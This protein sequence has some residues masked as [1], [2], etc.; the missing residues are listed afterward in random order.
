IMIYWAILAVS[1][2]LTYFRKYQEREFRLAQAQLQVLRMQLHPHFLFNTLNA[3]SE[4]VYQAPERADRTITQLSDLLRLSLKSGQEQEVP[5]KEELD[6][7]R[8]YVEIQ[9]T[10]M[11]ERLSV[12]WEIDPA[13]FDA[14]VPNMILQPLVENSIRHGI[15][16]RECGGQIKVS[17]RRMDD[18]LNLEVCDDGVGSPADAQPTPPGGVGLT[19]ARARLVHLYGSRHRFD[20][21]AASGSGLIVSIAIPFREFANP[22]GE[23]A[24]AAQG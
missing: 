17:A 6:F 23:D 20:L 3:I 21:R 2:A 10:L 19:N 18:M 7:L 8:K 12:R 14:L 15:A 5:H 1:Q 11:Q 4:L 16:A 13:S 22:P 24:H 9:Q